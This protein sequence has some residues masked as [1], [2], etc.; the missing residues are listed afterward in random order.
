MTGR[1]CVPRA[2]TL[3]VVLGLVP[4]LT[5]AGMTD[6]T[7][8]LTGL[9]GSEPAAAPSGAARAAAPAAAP[10][11]VPTEPQLQ[12]LQMPRDGVASALVDGQLLHA[13]QRW[14]GFEIVSIDAQGVLAKG[15]G[16]PQRWTLV[17]V[18]YLDPKARARRAVPLPSAPVAGEAASAAGAM[19]QAPISR[20]TPSLSTA[21]WQYTPV[22]A[23][24]PA[25]APS[26]P[27]V[28]RLSWADLVAPGPSAPP[29]APLRPAA[30]P[31]AEPVLR[32]P[33]QA[34]RMQVAAGPSQAPKPPVVAPSRAAASWRGL[35]FAW[36]TLARV[37]PRPA[38]RARGPLRGPLPPSVV[39]A[40]PSTGAGDPSHW[41]RHSAATD[42][43][44]TWW[45]PPVSL[46]PA[47][48]TVAAA[49]APALRRAPVRP[50]RPQP[51]R[52]WA[53]ALPRPASAPA[54]THALRAPLAPPALRL[55]GP[56]LVGVVAL[57]KETP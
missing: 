19:N 54:T 48:V 7:R 53:Q 24:T 32:L 41:T 51:A 52:A 23:P 15:P 36:P 6:P 47:P 46:R 9:P 26:L 29:P 50:L 38:V 12:S 1:S 33:S 14:N 22:P 5:C 56:H 39:L 42:A 27:P 10:A 35:P 31:R 18:Q 13:G 44:S 34:P 2:G 28:T 20:A 8:P 49:P 37:E 45:T 57:N 17:G 55:T 43:A 25:P 30:P 11:V 40:R 3:V 21:Q 16:G 4:G